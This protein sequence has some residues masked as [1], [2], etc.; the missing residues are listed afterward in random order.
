MLMENMEERN[1][2]LQKTGEDANQRDPSTE[3]L[4]QSGALHGDVH[5]TERNETFQEERNAESEND[6]EDEKAGHKKAES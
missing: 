1:D 2:K 5:P 3:H 4:E 6:I